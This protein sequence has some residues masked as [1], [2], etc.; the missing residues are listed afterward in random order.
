[1]LA[2]AGLQPWAVVVE[3]LYALMAMIAMSAAGRT[4]R[5]AGKANLTHR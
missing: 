3:H 4:A 5:V 1:M 2:D